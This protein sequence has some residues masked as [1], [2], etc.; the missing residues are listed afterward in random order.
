[1]IY[2]YYNP[3]AYNN[4]FYK[5]FNRTEKYC[6]PNK[7]L[8]MYLSF[9]ELSDE[10][11]EKYFE[12]FDIDEDAYLFYII[13]RYAQTRKRKR[14]EFSTHPYINS[15]K[16]DKD[17]NHISTLLGDANFK[18]WIKGTSDILSNVMKNIGCN[19]INKTTQIFMDEYLGNYNG[20][21]HEASIQFCGKNKVVTAFMHEPLYKLRY[22]HSFVEGEE[23][24][25]ETT[26]NLLIDK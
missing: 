17:Q 13:R 15:I 19:P 26:S 3:S 10:E 22:L 2:D 23:K 14:K 16:I 18:F 6:K 8:D 5:F 1:M 24:I 4:Y 7:Y 25:L 21:C 11:K 12:D 9:L 20:K